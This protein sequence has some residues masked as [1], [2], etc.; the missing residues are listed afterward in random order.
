MRRTQTRNAA[1]DLA[2]RLAFPLSECS[3]LDEEKRQPQD[4]SPGFVDVVMPEPP[5]SIEEAAELNLDDWELI[6]AALE[7]YSMCDVAG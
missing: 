5:V 2:K 4:R 3:R 1:N 7:H 6:Q